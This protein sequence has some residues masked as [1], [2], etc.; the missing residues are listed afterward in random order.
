MPTAEEKQQLAEA[1]DNAAAPAK[2]SVEECW[3]HARYWHEKGQPSLARMWKDLAEL[4]ETFEPTQPKL[5][6][7]QGG[8][9]A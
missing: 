3:D 1:I 4:G 8:H 7:I 6:V 5:K 2:P 9:D